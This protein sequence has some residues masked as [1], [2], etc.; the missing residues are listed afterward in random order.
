MIFLEINQNHFSTKYQ[1][2]CKQ[3]LRQVIGTNHYL[4]NNKKLDKKWWNSVL[5]WEI[6]FHCRSKFIYFP[7]LENTKYSEEEKGEDFEG[8]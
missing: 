7:F 5:C 4:Q 2:C 3:K 1:D 6:S 8:K